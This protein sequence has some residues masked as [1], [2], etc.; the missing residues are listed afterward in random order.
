MIDMA[1]VSDNIQRVKERVQVA[2]RRAGRNP[3]D[4]KILAA[5]KTVPPEIINFACQNGISLIGENRVQELLTKYDHLDRT[6]MDIH[7]IGTLQTNKVK[8]IIDK[9]SMIHSV[10]SL[11]LAQEID[12]QAVKIGL[13]MPVLIEVNLER[14][15]TKSGMN[16]EELEKLLVEVSKLKGVSVRGLMAIPPAE[17]VP[18][19]AADRKLL[20]AE[21][22]LDP[23]EEFC[24]KKE[25]AF[26]YF[27]KIQQIFIDISRKKI[28]NIVMQELS[29]GMSFDFEQAIQAGATIIRPGRVLFGEREYR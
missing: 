14:E 25:A 4:I 21:T 28:D 9:V 17:G 2:A 3:D 1:R 24:R 16:P 18:I 12:K 19:A 13:V 8:A 27:Q 23:E 26:E 5:T 7:F 15:S 22:T 6:R 29:L 11:H 20:H 10:N